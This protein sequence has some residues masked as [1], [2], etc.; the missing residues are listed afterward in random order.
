MLG[1]N[2]QAASRVNYP[3]VSSSRGLVSESTSSLKDVTCGALTAI[4]EYVKVSVL[5]NGRGLSHGAAGKVN[6]L[7]AVLCHYLAINGTIVSSV[8]ECAHQCPRGVE[9][10]VQ[11]EHHMSPGVVLYSPR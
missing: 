5:H 6:E 9:G 4:E 1:Y 2:A 3:T 8:S 10:G 7:I 11:S